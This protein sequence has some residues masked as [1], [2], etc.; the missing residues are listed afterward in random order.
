M[1]DEKA[2]LISV[3]QDKCV[4]CHQ[5]IAVCQEATKLCNDGSKD[6]VEVNPEMCIGCGEC[7]KACDHDAR[8]IVDEF[9]EFIMDV[10]SGKPMVAMIAPSIAANF[11]NN[12]ERINGW[13]KQ[14]CDVEAVFDVSFGAELTV[15]SYLEH[16]DSNAPDCVIAQPCPVIVDYI[17]LYQPDLMEYLAPADSPMLHTIKMIEEF[18]PQYRNHNVAVISPCI[19]KKR[20]FLQTGYGDKTYNITFQNL[21]KHFQNI[22]LR[23]YP[24]KGF[25]GP[26]AERA[27]GF[28][29]PGG[30]LRTVQRYLPEA[31]E[32]TKKIEGP[33]QVYDY[34]SEL[35]EAISKGHN[36]LLVDCL[37][38]A[39]GC[40]YGTGVDKQGKTEHELAYNVQQRVKKKKE[41]YEKEREK[42]KKTKLEKADDNDKNDSLFSRI[43][44]VFLPDKK[45]EVIENPI[46]PKVSK[47]DQTIN[48]YYKP[49][50]YTRSYKNLS[51]T[52]M[53]RLKEP[54]RREKDRIFKDMNKL[55]EDD[56]KINCA[57]CGYNSCELMVKAIHNGLNKLDNCH[58]YQQS[59]IKRQ[60]DTAQ[61]HIENITAESQELAAVAEQLDASNEMV[62]N[63]SEDTA[64]QAQD[65]LKYLEDIQ[66][67]TKE[68][69]QELDVLDEMSSTISG[70]SQ[71][72]NM[73]ALNAGI[74][75][76][77]V[78]NSEGF[79]VIAQEVR[80]LSDKT[81]EEIKRIDPYVEA[82]KEKLT[83][84]DKEIEDV[85]DGIE[86]S[87]DNSNEV[88]ASTQEIGAVISQV[89][90]SIQ[91]LSNN[92]EEFLSDIQE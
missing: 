37:N 80:H 57:A 42:E 10:K 79:S 53:N 76:A 52:A 6:Y 8:L 26:N 60:K 68:I 36:P 31:R 89:N 66:K 39:A 72:T 21:V 55:D 67:L 7:I 51:L 23:R 75:A 22:N 41:E 25:D 56:R 63:R 38:C 29:T 18:Y 81:D 44:N 64:K 87:V 3:D 28:S 20:E 5:C 45:Q 1:E 35:K 86:T 59:I 88:V 33:D 2:R 65:G 90:R 11:P 32:F 77:H 54:N 49:N 14:E 62:V 91:T 61:T 43:K 34:L 15:K 84:I 24:K 50:L 58:Y 82:F 40:N 9:D 73:L 74:E 69:V 30:L 92:S 19:G 78:E 83:K 12:Y 48:D 4:N 13:L 85:L 46:K 16:I 71:Q 17:Q 27:A 70:I 47:L